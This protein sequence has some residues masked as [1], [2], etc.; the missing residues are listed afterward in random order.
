MA[1]AQAGQQAG[2]IM[3]GIEPSPKVVD[4]KVLLNA[5]LK[6]Q[7]DSAQAEDVVKVLRTDLLDG[8]T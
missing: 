6:Y 2:A 7:S 4:G 8:L 5:T 1:I 3:A